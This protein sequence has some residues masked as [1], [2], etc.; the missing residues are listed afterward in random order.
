M[1]LFAL[2]KMLDPSYMLSTVLPMLEAA[3]ANASGSVSKAVFNRVIRDCINA[4]TTAD[5]DKVV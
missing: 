4:L 2:S 1:G 3:D 5:C